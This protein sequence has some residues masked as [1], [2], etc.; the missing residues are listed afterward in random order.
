PE[1]EWPNL[2][3]ECCSI[4]R[5]SISKMNVKPRATGDDNAG[6]SL[7]AHDTDQQVAVNR[8]MSGEAPFGNFDVVLFL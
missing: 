8:R 2:Q 4:S 7:A 3:N 5:S 1:T 6:Y